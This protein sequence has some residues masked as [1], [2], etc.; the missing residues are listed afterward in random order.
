MRVAASD[1]VA[2]AAFSRLRR[3]FFARLTFL[4]STAA[5]AAAP[6]SPVLEYRSSGRFASARSMTLSTCFG[7]SGTMSRADGIGSFMWAHIRAA[8]V[9][10]GYGNSPVSAS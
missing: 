9:S 6:S 1:G 4:P 10:R 8:S 5:I 3:A 2:A 7:S